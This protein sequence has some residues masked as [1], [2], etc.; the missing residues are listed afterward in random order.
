VAPVPTA[1]ER[2]GVPSTEPES[3]RIGDS[4][5][6]APAVTA[7]FDLSTLAPSDIVVVLRG[8]ERRYR[9]LFTALAEE[10][11]AD[12]VARRPGPDGCS[13]VDHIVAATQ[14]IATADR[15]LRRVLT[16]EA[17]TLQ[18]AEID[19]PPRPGPAPASSVEELLAELGRV[20]TAAADRIE[21]VAVGDWTR[22]ATVADGSGRT[23]TALDIVRSMVDA[24][25]GHLRAAR[26][27]LEAVRG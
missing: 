5:A 24:G 7:G 12:D 1:C 27:V 19:G 17:P 2:A 15:A 8:L 26:E 23:V 3:R 4:R 14:A 9:E 11:S 16:T 20:S 6:S 22:Q 13:A 25:V 21:R 18:P 10:E